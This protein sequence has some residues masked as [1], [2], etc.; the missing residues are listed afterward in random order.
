MSQP[1]E[2]KP[3]PRLLAKRCV[4]GWMMPTNPT[5][6]CSKCGAA[7]QPNEPALLSRMVLK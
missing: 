3:P 2:A 7:Q 4:C 1:L 5:R 6:A